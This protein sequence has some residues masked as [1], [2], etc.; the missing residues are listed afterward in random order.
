MQRDTPIHLLFADP[1]REAPLAWADDM[2]AVPGTARVV[3][4]G[5]LEYANGQFHIERAGL[6][7]TAVIVPNSRC[8][9]LDWTE[10]G[11]LIYSKQRFSRAD[12]GHG[13]TQVCC[14]PG[15]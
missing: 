12:L 4:A 5:A 7:H 15:G 13:E 8:Y 3:Y 11:H 14:G 9:L 1:P 10:R 6:N 2:E